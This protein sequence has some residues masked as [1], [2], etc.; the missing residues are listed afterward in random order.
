[1]RRLSWN[2][3]FQSTHVYSWQV[4]KQTQDIL[5]LLVDSYLYVSFVSPCL[6]IAYIQITADVISCQI[7]QHSPSARL[8]LFD[9]ISASNIVTPVVNDTFSW[10]KHHPYV[11]TSSFM[12]S[13]DEYGYPDRVLL[14]YIALKNK[15]CIFYFHV[16]LGIFALYYWHFR[17][18][19]FFMDTFYFILYFYH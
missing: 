18:I 2:R 10:W 3:L 5:M 16:I 17:C 7:L 11:V 9:E 15:I 13:W 4:C 6:I 12:H 8:Y 1:M 14:Q 19:L